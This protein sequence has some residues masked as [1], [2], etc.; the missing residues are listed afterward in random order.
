MQKFILACCFLLLS[1]SCWTQTVKIIHQVFEVDTISEISL[2]LHGEYEL[3][4]WAGNTV[5]SETR[6]KIYDAPQHVVN[7]FIDEKGRYAI[8]ATSAE[9]K[10]LL[11]SKDKERVE[12]K[13]KG[14]HCYEEVGLRLYVP[15][16]F[17]IIDQQTLRKK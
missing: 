6:I 9:A 2:D 12:I 14:I 17:E 15:D 13:Y 7:H 11:T 3:Q 5:M 4:A 8:D 10:L 16:S 1:Q